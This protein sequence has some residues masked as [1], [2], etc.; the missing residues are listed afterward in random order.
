M[1]MAMLAAPQPFFSCFTKGTSSQT[2]SGST[3]NR[4]PQRHRGMVAILR[5][6]RSIGRLPHRDDDQNERG[7]TD[8]D[9]DQ[10]TVA[11]SAGCKVG[12]RLVGARS[13]LSQ[14]LVIQIGDGVLHLFCIDMRGLEGFFRKGR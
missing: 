13:Q 10:V 12:L 4:T 7:D 1:T 9:D 2:P 8:Q 14:F 5:M 11:E 6:L 3:A